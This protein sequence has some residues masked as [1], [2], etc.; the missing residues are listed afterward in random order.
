MRIWLSER[1]RITLQRKELME[2]LIWSFGVRQT[3]TSG[4]TENQLAD[5]L[6]KD[7]NLEGDR[8]IEILFHMS[9]IERLRKEEK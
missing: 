9:E 6:L 4:W 1:A 2:K 5:F 8:L 3:V 7:H